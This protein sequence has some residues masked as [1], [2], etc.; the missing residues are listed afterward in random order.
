MA[1]I[2]I[3]RFCRGVGSYVEVAISNVESHPTGV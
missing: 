1:G 2:F 3:G